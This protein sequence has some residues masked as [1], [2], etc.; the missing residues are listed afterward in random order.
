[1]EEGLGQVTGY[2]DTHECFMRTICEVAK[3]P[4][5]GDGIIGDVFNLLL[6]PIQDVKV[7]NI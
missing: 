4:L 7:I 2:D 6:S 1:M 5:S 3:T